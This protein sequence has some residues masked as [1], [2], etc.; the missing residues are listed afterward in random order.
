MT[1]WRV[2][3]FFRTDFQN[4]E[5]IL[6]YISTLVWIAHDVYVHNVRVFIGYKLSSGQEQYTLAEVVYWVV[7]ADTARMRKITNTMQSL[8]CHL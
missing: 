8:E 5:G 1:H 2:S 4:G 3:D 6:S 7:G